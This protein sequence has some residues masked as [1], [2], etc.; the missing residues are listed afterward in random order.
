[1][2]DSNQ[3]NTSFNRKVKDTAEIAKITNLLLNLY[4]KNP[5]SYQYLELE[6]MTYK[7]TET[8]DILDEV[9]WGLQFLQ[10]AQNANGGL[11]EGIEQPFEFRQ[12]YKLLP[13]SPQATAL[14]ISALTQA[15]KIYKKSNLS[16]A[17]SLIITAEK[18]WEYLQQNPKE[19]PICPKLPHR[20]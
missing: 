17:V 11:P 18:A 19:K 13:D 3:S 14:G 8:P 20:K 1:M 10:T 6:G 4:A 7:E 12:D 2:D 16:Y 5:E 15:S 9:N